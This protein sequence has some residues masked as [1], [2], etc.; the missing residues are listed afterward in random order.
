MKRGILY[1]SNELMCRAVKMCFAGEG[2]KLY[3]FFDL[4]DLERQLV[5]LQADF[6]L[7]DSASLPMTSLQKARFEG[8]SIAL[9]CLGEDLGVGGWIPRPINP[10]IL[11]E[12]VLDHTYGITKK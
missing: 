10:R 11:L 6:V 3:D 12:K 1:T 2:V 9:F 5:E 7:F 8:F 4:L